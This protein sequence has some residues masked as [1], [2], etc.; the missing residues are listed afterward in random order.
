[1]IYFMTLRCSPLDIQLFE[2]ITTLI[3]G[4]YTERVSYAIEKDK[5]P[6]RHLH[7]LTTTSHRDLSHFKQSLKKKKFEPFF[8]LLKSKNTE[9]N[10]YALDIQTIK[11]EDYNLTLGY[12]YKETFCER[13]ST[14]HTNEEVQKAIEE[15][16]SHKRLETQ[17][18]PATKKIVLTVKN[19]HS[20][21]EKF[22]QEFPEESVDDWY[23]LKKKMILNNYSF[24]DMSERKIKIAINELQIC[25]NPN[26]YLYQTE[27]I[28][29]T[30]IKNPNYQ[31]GYRD[32]KMPT[33]LKE[34]SQEIYKWEK[35]NKDFLDYY[36]HTHN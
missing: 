5:T 29:E 1:M 23:S 30:F 25:K 10:Q 18:T 6:D 9:T 4:E 15:Y 21:I 12:I 17:L 13:R 31:P 34:A 35:E 11:E 27:D 22:L 16:Y 28:Q 19:F 7:M 26:H 8:K 24:M 2:D 32:D 33:Y 36:I 14:F 20:Y 3:L